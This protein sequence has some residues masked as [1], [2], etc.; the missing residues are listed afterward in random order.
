MRNNPGTVSSLWMRC[1]YSS[2]K[3]NCRVEY[4]DLWLLFCRINCRVEISASGSGSG[5]AWTYWK[6]VSNLSGKISEYLVSKLT[7]SPIMLAGLLVHCFYYCPLYRSLFMRYLTVIEFAVLFMDSFPKTM[8]RGSWLVVS[9]GHSCCD[10][11][12]QTLNRVKS[13]MSVAVCRCRSLKLIQILVS[14]CIVENLV[15]IQNI[16]NVNKEYDI[17]NLS[18]FS[19]HIQW[20]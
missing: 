16:Y 5:P 15:E 20:K 19:S 17:K 3:I 12:K 8:W 9:V 7:Y 4:Y 6:L 11:V 18:T 13:L 10:S 1:S 14:C 2:M